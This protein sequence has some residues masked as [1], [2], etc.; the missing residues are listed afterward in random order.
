MAISTGFYAKCFE[1]AFNGLIDWDT[2]TIKAQLMADAH[3]PDFDTHD[4]R[5]DVSANE[6]PGATAQTIP[7][8]AFSYDAGTN[9]FRLDETGTITFTT[10]TAGTTV[11][12]VVIYKDTGAAATDCLIA[13]LAFG[14]TFNTNGQDVTVTFNANGIGEITY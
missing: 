4:F 10:P 2:N 13:L 6:A 12:G 11:G 14:S 9:K 8:R 1:H 3:V 5:A 7:S